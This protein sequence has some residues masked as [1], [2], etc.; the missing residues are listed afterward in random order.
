MDQLKRGDE[1]SY[2]YLY[3]HYYVLLC[4]ISYEIVKDRFTAETIVGDFIFHLWEIRSELSI[5]TSLV[6]YF[7]QSIRNRSIN[8]LQLERHQKEV[9]L[10]TLTVDEASPS[11]YLMEDSYP[12]GLLLEQELE[13][14]IAAAVEQLPS[15]SK[16]VFRKSRFEHKKYAEIAEEMHISVNTVKCHM[17]SALKKL[18]LDLAKYLLLLYLFLTYLQNK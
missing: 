7:I 9:S 5:S 10:S 13:E 18:Q 6:S 2:K 3:D 4:R 1:S 12:L 8:Y 11:S 16:A 17:K 15:E 14:A